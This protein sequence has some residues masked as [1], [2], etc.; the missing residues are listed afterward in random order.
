MGNRPT[1][2]AV[3]VQQRFSTRRRGSCLNPPPLRRANGRHCQGSATGYCCDYASPPDEGEAA[4]LQ[5]G[6]SVPTVA[7]AF[8]ASISK[9]AVPSLGA[10]AFKMPACRAAVAAASA[11]R[12][13]V[14]VAA[15]SYFAT[16]RW[17]GGP[18]EV[19]G[20]VVGRT[21]GTSFATAFKKQPDFTTLCGRD[22]SAVCTALRRG[23]SKIRFEAGETSMT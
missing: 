14:L 19:G 4:P 15:S 1:S 3:D 5:T 10:N 12:G 18:I 20:S 17:A 11:S 7:G 2:P 23:V 6:P 13:E 16:V 21:P 22:L 9:H 8:L